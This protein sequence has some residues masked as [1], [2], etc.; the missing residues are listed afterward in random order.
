M[1]AQLSL[2][3]PEDSH[4]GSADQEEHYTAERDREK[5]I[6]PADLAEGLPNANG[7][8]P[9]ASDATDPL[10]TLA[11]DA[12]L[13]LMI[14]VDPP[15]LHDLQDAALKSRYHLEASNDADDEPNQAHWWVQ[16]RWVKIV[17]FAVG[18]PSFLYLQFATDLDP[19][20]TLL[21]KIAF[22]G[23]ISVVVLQMIFVFR[24]YW[25]MDI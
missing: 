11:A 10:R 14:G 1:R 22:G 24:A 17:T 18:V 13:A 19:F 3:S 12:R 4:Q 16:P 20:A 21:G 23:F 9:P 2:P 5:R 8:F 15:P 25:R 6:H 7:S